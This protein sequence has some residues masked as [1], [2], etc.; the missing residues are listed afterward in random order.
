MK[1]PMLNE[2]WKPVLGYEGLYK[3]S[4][5]GN[6]ISIKRKVLRNGHLMSVPEINLKPRL[7][8]LGYVKVSMSKSGINKGH[9]VHRLVAKAFIPKL[10]GC[11]E[12]N[13]IDGNKENNNVENLEWCDRKH[14][15]RHSNEMGLVK[16]NKGLSH[17]NSEPVIDLDSGVF[18][19]SI[20]DAANNLGCDRCYLSKKLKGELFNNTNLIL[21]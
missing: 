11:N 14:N 7:T 8:R 10:K 20:K 16:R 17:P 4:N 3:V 13:H 1:P 21:A 6:V 18:Y 9:F 2:I 12:I 15:I 5:K 19:N